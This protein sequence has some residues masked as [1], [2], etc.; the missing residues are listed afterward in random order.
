MIFW[1][2]GLILTPILGLAQDLVQGVTRPI[3]QLRKKQRTV[4]SL[5]QTMSLATKLKA[6]SHL[7]SMTICNFKSAYFETS[8]FFFA[9]NSFC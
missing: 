5:F 1:V 3:L 8:S 2:A 9:K 6:G 7:T 4:K